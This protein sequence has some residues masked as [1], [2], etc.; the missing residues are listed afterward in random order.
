MYNVY[1]VEVIAGHSIE[2]IHN[3]EKAVVGEGDQQTTILNTHKFTYSDLTAG[4]L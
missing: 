1:L 4:S 2:E 3:A